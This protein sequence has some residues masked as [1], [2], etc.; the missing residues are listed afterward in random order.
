M[1]RPALHGP[2]HPA[3]LTAR[4]IRTYVREKLR[5]FAERQ[6]ERERIRKE[7]KRPSPQKRLFE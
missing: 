1:K 6:A 5:G 3:A 4:V 7:G 2:I